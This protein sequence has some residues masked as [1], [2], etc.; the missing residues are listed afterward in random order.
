MLPLPLLLPL[1][2]A[3][4]LCPAYDMIATSTARYLDPERYQ[5]FW[6]EVYSHNVPLVKSCHCTRYNFTLS[7]STTFTD[8]FTCRKKAPDAPLY[9]IHNKGS[10]DAAEPG[11]MRESLGPTSPP[12]WVKR[13][14][15]ASHSIDT[16]TAPAFA[17]R[18]S[19]NID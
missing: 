7:G 13:P 17:P 12:Y 10:F 5:G 4:L 9:T 16:R 8:D 6:Y 3:S 14:D 19:P 2:Q 18:L 11:K 1:S 15:Y